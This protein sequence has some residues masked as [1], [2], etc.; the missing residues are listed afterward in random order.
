MTTP[1][2]QLSLFSDVEPVIRIIDYRA[3]ETKILELHRLRAGL[4]RRLLLVID[5][6]YDGVY[7]AKRWLRKLPA[8]TR[9][10]ETIIRLDP[11]R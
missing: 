11:K 9:R 7:I 5:S 4:R 6:P 3:G 1:T 10:N 2:L 8:K